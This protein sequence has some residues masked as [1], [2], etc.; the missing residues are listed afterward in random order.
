M[1]TESAHD[2]PAAP[3]LKLEPVENVATEAK[4][5]AIQVKV[6]EG[7]KASKPAVKVRAK[8]QKVTWV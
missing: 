8:L 1:V 7:S 3:E 2:L 6:E 5:D 4:A